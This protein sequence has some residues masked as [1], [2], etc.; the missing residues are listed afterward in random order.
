MLK[1]YDTKRAQI[2]HDLLEIGDIVI[3]SLNTALKALKDDEIKSLK[4]ADLS[5]KKLTAKSNDIDNAIVTALALY[6]PEAKDLRELVSYL[7]I[8]NEL[9]RAGENTKVFIKVFRAAFSD[10]LNTK[11]ILEFA[12]P[13]LKST[14]LSLQTSMLIIKEEN[15]KHIEEKY[16][17]VVVEESKTDDL[18]AMIE[19][20]ILKLISKNLDLSKEYFDILTSLRKLE[21]ISDRSVAIAHLLLFAEKGGE[22]ERK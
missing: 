16:Q 2:Q 7:K 18:Y 6:Q 8:T 20:N 13:L 14:I 3:E 1:V 10:D 12:I 5:L 15:S 21:N 9:S 11:T 22:L 4:G 17:R 19:K